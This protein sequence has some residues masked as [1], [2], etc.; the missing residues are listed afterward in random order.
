M[1][2]LSD[3]N[4]SLMQMTC[5]YQ[6]VSVASMTLS[7]FNFISN[8]EILTNI[9]RCDLTDLQRAQADVDRKILC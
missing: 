7:S 6:Q 5:L 3:I 2:L 8:R 1:C 9:K 4:K